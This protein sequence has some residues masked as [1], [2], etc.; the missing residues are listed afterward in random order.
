M[1]NIK[2]MTRII[3]LYFSVFAFQ[4][5]HAIEKL[6]VS[7]GDR[8]NQYTVDFIKVAEQEIYP[9]LVKNGHKIQPVVS[10]ELFLKHIQTIAKR[11]DSKDVVYESCDASTN[12]RI[13]AACYNSVTDM[14]WLNQKLY[15]LDLINSQ[16]KRLLIMHEVFRRM[17]L[18]GDKYE[19]TRKLSVT[20]TNPE[21]TSSCIIKYYR[22]A[23]FKKS[24]EKELA[25][26]T[27]EKNAS[28]PLIQKCVLNLNKF[29]KFESLTEKKLAIDSCEKTGGEEAFQKYVID[30]YENAGFTAPEE[31]QK[32]IESYFR[33]K[34]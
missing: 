30:L 18:E 3:S 12:G 24:E 19:V 13:V 26:Q 11:I 1:M 7:S 33:Q 20:I 5:A 25:V 29:A 2:L 28:E 17:G 32:A 23:D 15:P 4:S 14:I 34:S 6:G 27:C 8:G 22:D 31:K 21:I 16:A 9:W 10:A